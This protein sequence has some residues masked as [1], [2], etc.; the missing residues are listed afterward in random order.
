MLTTAK[1]AVEDLDPEQQLEVLE[2]FHDHVEL[3]ADD[4]RDEIGA[5]LNED[6][7]DDEEDEY[8]DSE[9]EEDEDE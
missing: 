6:E 8:E 5:A 4:L 1:Q 9:L 2:L 3:Y 7:E